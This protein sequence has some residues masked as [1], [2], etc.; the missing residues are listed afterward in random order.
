M[1]I[2]IKK[3]VLSEQTKQTT[4]RDS[5]NQSTCNSHDFEIHNAEEISASDDHYKDLIDVDDDC[6]D[7]FSSIN[8]K[9]LQSVFTLLACRQC[10]GTEVGLKHL[11]K[12]R[13]GYS[14]KFMVYCA[15]CHWEHCFFSSPKFD[16]P[17]RDK[18]GKGTF[19]I[20]IRAVMAFRELGKGHEAMKTFNAVMNM[21]PPIST[22][23]YID[24][25]DKIHDIYQV[26]AN[27]S[28]KAA[29]DNV[30]K[31]I[32]ANAGE[33]D[34]IDTDISI[35]GSWQKRGHSSLNGVVTGVSPVNKKV[36]D[37]LVYTKFRPICARQRRTGNKKPHVCKINHI[38]SSGRMESAGA[39]AFFHESTTKYGLRYANYIGDG[40][41]ESFKKVLDSKPYGDSLIPKKLECVGHVQKR[42]GTRLRKLRTNLKGKLLPDGKK[43]SG[44][45]RLTDKIINKMQN[46]FGMAIRQNTAASW[47]GDKEKALYAM[48]KSVLAVLWH[49]TAIEDGN[50]RHQFCTR[51]VDSWCT[52]WKNKDT[53]HKCSVNLPIAIHNE[54]KSIFMDLRSDA[55][56]SRCLEGTTQ[57]PNEA[58]NQIIWKKCPKDVF[59]CKDILDI[60]VASAIVNYNDGLSG[61]GNIF[62]SMNLKFG[63]HGFIGASKKDDARA[64]HKKRK[65]TEIF[66]TDRKK[67][68]GMRKGFIDSEKHVEGGESYCSGS[69]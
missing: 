58:F 32:N 55:L 39:V 18:R 31:V 28:M 29:T 8:F 43:I 41:T 50:V 4:N 35:D 9:I 3:T 48:K 61:L 60:G 24:I 53:Q 37:C 25:N 52:F 19:E 42:L 33:N 30:R 51:S 57:N 11:C 22:R 69:F 2:N 27:K 10:G 38:E 40:D 68:R 16:F 14:L 54:V 12:E 56:L 44:K 66:T 15:E 21:C 65:S 59:V 7:F 34:V 64:R 63:Y 5:S 23:T 47:E 1:E 36:I 26:A 62:H 45:G 20:N 46:Y 13:Q 17:G 6:D 67:L 49:C